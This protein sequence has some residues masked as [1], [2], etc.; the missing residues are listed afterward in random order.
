MAGATE[1]TIEILPMVLP[2]PSG[3]TRV[4]TV[5]INNGIIIAV[6]T[7]WI[8][9]PKIKSS[10]P[11]DTAQI[12]VPTLKTLIAKIKIGRVFIRWIKNPVTGI[13]TAI[14]SK[15]AVV[16]HCTAPAVTSKANIKRGNATVMMVSFK[17]TTNVEI[18]SNAITNRFRPE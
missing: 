3:G 15:K 5:V 13:T 1:M 9:R 17:N 18:S 10:S 11:G 14:V 12:K 2:R 6:P 7:A 8:T 16:N 4:I